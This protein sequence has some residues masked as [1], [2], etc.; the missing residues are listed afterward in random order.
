MRSRSTTRGGP[1][2]TFIEGVIRP[3]TDIMSVFGDV[4]Q[5]WLTCEPRNEWSVGNSHRK[6]SVADWKRPTL[7][8]MADRTEE[9]TLL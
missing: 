3:R 1:L 4:R 7:E 5:I 9:R 8:R 2:A 6:V